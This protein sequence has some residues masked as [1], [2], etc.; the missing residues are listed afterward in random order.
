MMDLARMEELW[1]MACG[2][3]A[4]EAFALA[5]RREALEEAEVV[6][7]DET[8]ELRLVPIVRR[9]ERQLVIRFPAPADLI[10]EAR[11]SGYSHGFSDRAAM[12]E[13]RYPGLARR[14]ALEEAARV[15]DE[16]NDGY[17]SFATGGGGW[18]YTGNCEDAIRALID[19]VPAR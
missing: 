19:A 12:D 2:M 16:L 11:E 14:E 9:D 7:L 8:G 4:L 5:V 6:L 1:G 18:M 13:T 15:C 3:D 17:D 10:R